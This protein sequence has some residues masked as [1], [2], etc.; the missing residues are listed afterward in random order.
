MA[1]L[2]ERVH[3]EVLATMQRKLSKG[4]EFNDLVT[5]D[6][7]TVDFVGC[8]VDSCLLARVTRSTTVLPAH[9]L[10]RVQDEWQEVARS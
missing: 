1:R 3:P 7:E 2:S 5:F 9:K 10:G 4:A 8:A 6:E